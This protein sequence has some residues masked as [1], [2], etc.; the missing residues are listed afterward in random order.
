MGERSRVPNLK[1]VLA[2]FGIPKFALIHLP[3]AFW[4]DEFIH[5]MTSGVL[6]NALHPFWGGKGETAPRGRGLHK[7]VT[8]LTEHLGSNHQDRLL[9][10]KLRVQ[11][12]L[13][14]N[15]QRKETKQIVHVAAPCSSLEVEKRVKSLHKR[16]SFR[17]T[18]RRSQSLA[19]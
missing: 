9:G 8:S 14:L 19:R 17:C 4:R 6:V 3:A 11:V 1:L 16:G 18:S 15:G 2:S 12:W 13:V 5:S 7:P 10:V